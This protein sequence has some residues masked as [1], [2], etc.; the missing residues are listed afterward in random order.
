MGALRLLRTFTGVAWSD[1]LL[2]YVWVIKH[3]EGL[4][5]V[6]TGET[7]ASPNRATSRRGT[8]RRGLQE[9]V[10]PEEEIGKL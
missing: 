2:I 4:F 6:D 8:F 9:R 1:W 10:K 5:V 3:P 7:A